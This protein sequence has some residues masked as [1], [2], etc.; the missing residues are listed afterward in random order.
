PYTFESLCGDAKH[1]AANLKNYI[2]SFSDNM[3][4][5]IEKFDFQNT[6]AKLEEA[7]LLFL[8]TERFKNIDLHPDKVSNLEM[9]YVFEELIRKFNEAMDENPG[10]HFTPREVIRLMVNLMTFHDE[11][12][13]KAGNVIRTIYDPCCGTGG[14]LTVAKQ[15][16]QQINPNSDVHL[17]GQE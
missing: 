12:E 5:V 1:L 11:T 15:R 14:M 2:N 17:F 6:I 16:I 7:G 4:E 3:R 10:E 13:L 8:V 9:G